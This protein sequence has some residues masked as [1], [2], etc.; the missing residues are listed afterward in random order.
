MRMGRVLEMYP[1]LTRDGFRPSDWLRT[2]FSHSPP[3]L[4]CVDESVAW[5][6]KNHARIHRKSINLR[7][8]SYGMKHVVEEETGKYVSNG[9]FIC[10]AIMCGYKIKAVKSQPLN[11][12]LNMKYPVIK[13]K[14]N[15]ECHVQRISNHR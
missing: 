13:R 3:D 11:V 6:L 1:D 7:I 12:F 10:A 8:T 9:D 5:I 4:V 2:F 14:L 15:V